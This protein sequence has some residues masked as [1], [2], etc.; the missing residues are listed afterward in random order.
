MI[1]TDFLIKQDLGFALQL[2]NFCGKLGAHQANLGL[3]LGDVTDAIDTYE[4]LKFT[5]DMQSAHAERVKSWTAFKDIL[6]NPGTGLPPMSNAPVTLVVPTAPKTVNLGIDLWFRQIV[7][8]IKGSKNYTEGIG[9]DLGILSISSTIDLATMQP[10]LSIQLAAG[11]PI[12]V[13]KKM[14]MDGVEIYK[15]N[16]DGKWNLLVL[17]LRP[18]HLDTTPLPVLGTTATWKYKAIYRFQ[19]TR[20]G[21]WSNEVS[22]NVGAAV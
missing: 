1:N 2:K 15:D 7:K 16:G 10:T 6:R 9:K 11:Q 13:W 3:T 20:I 12:I 14:G 21:L 17:D 19:D 18:N 4:F 22:V 8:R 5:L